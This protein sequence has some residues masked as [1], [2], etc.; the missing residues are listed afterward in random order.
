[1]SKSHEELKYM[2]VKNVLIYLVQ[3][4]YKTDRNR[5]RKRNVQVTEDGAV[6]SDN[7]GVRKTTTDRPM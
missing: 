7:L 3:P 1:M 5:Y 2:I 6:T 4:I